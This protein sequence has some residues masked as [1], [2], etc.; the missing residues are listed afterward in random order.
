MEKLRLEGASP[1]SD[2]PMGQLRINED[3]QD[4]DW[5][6]KHGIITTSEYKGLLNMAGLEPSDV[7]FID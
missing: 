5:A 2:V 3:Q 7:E 6:L 4:A 1:L